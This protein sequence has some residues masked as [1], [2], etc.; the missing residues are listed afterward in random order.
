MWLREYQQDLPKERLPPFEDPLLLSITI[1]CR[2]DS[3]P[4]HYWPF[5]GILSWQAPLNYFEGLETES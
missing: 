5:Y 2:G 3:I 1:C 4:W